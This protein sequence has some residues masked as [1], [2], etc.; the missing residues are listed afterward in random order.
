MKKEKKWKKKRLYTILGMILMIG[1]IILS[2]MDRNLLW[3]EKP[4]KEVFLGVQKGMEL[5]LESFSSKNTNLDFTL[6]QEK[7]RE[8]ASLKELLGLKN[9]LSNFDIVY[10]TTVN[11]NVSTFQEILTIDKGSSDGLEKDMA[12]V[13]QN[14][15]IGKLD[16]VSYHFS[17]VKLLTSTSE[18]RYQVSVM[19]EGEENYF[20]ILNQYSTEQETF[21]ITGIP[22]NSVIQEGDIVTTSG[23]GGI[24]PSGI[25]VGTVTN[26]EEDGYGISKQIR[27]KSEQNFRDIKYVAVLKREVEE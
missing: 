12:V 26:V 2:S 1:L 8:I 16:K 13:T 24:F 27:L 9:I 19:V 4:L 14:G 11:R 17:E 22:S 10:A 20:G 21:Y 18:N 3:I 15:L 7:T 5:P 6:S 23:L 25:M